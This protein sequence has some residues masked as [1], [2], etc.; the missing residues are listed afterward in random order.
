M[1]FFRQFLSWIYKANYNYDQKGSYNPKE[2]LIQPFVSLI[3][4]FG[5]ISILFVA[6]IDNFANLYLAFL[7]LIISI[8]MACLYRIPYQKGKLDKYISEEIKREQSIKREEKEFWNK[9]IL[10]REKI[11]E[12]MKKTNERFKN[13]KNNQ[14]NQEKDYSYKPASLNFKNNNWRIPHLKVLGL[15]EFA[16]QKQ[17][18]TSYRKLAMQLH[19]DRNPNNKQ[20]EEKFKKMKAAY[21]SLC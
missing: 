4:I 13:L 8:A 3:I 10:E 9:M 6:N 19:P 11:I 1:K 18:K 16:T 5:L 7:P 14:Q 2:I 15:N 12:E 21:E 17:I 20:A